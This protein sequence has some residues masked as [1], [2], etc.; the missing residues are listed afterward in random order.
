MTWPEWGKSFG[1]RWL[2]K[3]RSP[4]ENIVDRKSFC[5]TVLYLDFLPPNVYE[6]LFMSNSRIVTRKGS[7]FFQFPGY[8]SFYAFRF[9]FYLN[10]QSESSKRRAE[11]RKG[12]FNQKSIIM[13]RLLRKMLLFFSSFCPTGKAD[14]VRNWETSK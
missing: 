9:S 12:H 4:S 11:E 14:G 6:S 13:T 8:C 5:A 1:M 7:I 3:E 10:G 2:S